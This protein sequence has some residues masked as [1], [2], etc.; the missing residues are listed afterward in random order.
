MDVNCL[1]PR[2]GLDWFGGWLPTAVAVGYYR[3]P[4]CGWILD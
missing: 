3:S 1:L 4:L 2:P